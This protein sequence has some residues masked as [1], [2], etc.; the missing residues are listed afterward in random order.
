MDA[1]KKENGVLDCAQ[2]PLDTFI[3]VI[4][5]KINRSKFRTDFE[6]DCAKTVYGFII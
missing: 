4:P 3:K 5:C 1:G 2:C 6:K